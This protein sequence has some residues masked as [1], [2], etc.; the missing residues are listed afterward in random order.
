MTYAL[1]TPYARSS[2]CRLSSHVPEASSSH[3]PVPHPRPSAPIPTRLP[4]AR[5]RRSA[6]AWRRSRRAVRRLHLSARNGDGRDAVGIAGGARL[7]TEHYVSD[8]ARKE[9]LRANAALIRPVARRDPPPL[10]RPALRL[11]V[12]VP[13]RLLAPRRPDRPR[14]EVRLPRAG[15]R[16]PQRRLRRAALLPG[17]EAPAG[18]API[19]GADVAI[20]GAGSALRAATAHRSAQAATLRPEIPEAAKLP[21][22]PSSSRAAPATGISAG[23]HRRGARQAEGRGR[24]RPARARG[25]YRRPHCLAGGDDGPVARARERG[26][27][28]RFEAAGSSTGSAPSLPAPRRGRRS[29]RQRREEARRRPYSTWRGAPRSDRRDERRPLRDASVRALLDVLSA[30]SSAP[31]STPPARCSTPNAIPT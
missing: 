1:F 16:R 23:D 28:A 14:R 26:R 18:C 2:L 20:E 5:W 8:G 10:R 24:R 19:V 29:S 6:G 27:A 7:F 31:R 4:L 3:P 17:R 12:L 9:K 13:R 11:G 15:T 25:A 21:L 30:C 22:S